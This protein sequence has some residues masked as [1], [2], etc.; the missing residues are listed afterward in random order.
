LRDK[1]AQIASSAVQLSVAVISR[2]PV[3]LSAW[4]PVRGTARPD[5]HWRDG[6]STREPASMVWLCYHQSSRRGP[7]GGTADITS[8]ETTV[9]VELRAVWPASSARSSISQSLY[10]YGLP[11]RLKLSAYSL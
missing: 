5:H 1:C 9:L 11:P 8:S 10:L 7:S 4:P 2:A 3:D 6:W